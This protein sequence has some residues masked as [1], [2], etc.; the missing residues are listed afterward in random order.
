[1]KHIL[2]KRSTPGW[3]KEFET[4]ESAYAELLT[5]ICGECLSGDHELIGTTERHAMTP[6]N[7]AVIEDLLGTPCGCEYDFE[8]EK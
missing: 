2:H 5:H 8:V 4:E 3:S 1:M 7:P 6:P